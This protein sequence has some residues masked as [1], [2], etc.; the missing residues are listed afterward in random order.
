VTQYDAPTDRHKAV[1]SATE[2]GPESREGPLKPKGFG[3][4][5]FIGESWMYLPEIDE[6]VHFVNGKKVDLC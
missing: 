5:T 4:V 6:W 1:S 2:A 3:P